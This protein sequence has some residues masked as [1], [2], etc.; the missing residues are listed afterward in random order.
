MD[1]RGMNS[2]GALDGNDGAGIS[3]GSGRGMLRSM[4][5]RYLL[6]GEG[7]TQGRGAGGGEAHS[8]PLLLQRPC[9]LF[10]LHLLL[11]D[12]LQQSRR[13]LTLLHTHYTAPRGERGALHTFRRPRVN[14]STGRRC[15]TK[16]KTHL[17]P[18]REHC[19]YGGY[20]ISGADMKQEVCNTVFL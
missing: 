4:R 10:K 2:I 16:T 5:L 19:R 3:G 18:H 17:S 20:R 1:V 13:A 9:Q 15:L 6:V 7:V 8:P 12:R 11:P 14:Y